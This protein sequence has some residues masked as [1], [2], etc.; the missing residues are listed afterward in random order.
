MSMT[1]DQLT[2]SVESLRDWADTLGADGADVD[3]LIDDAALEV[4]VT[5]RISHDAG[6]APESLTIV[7]GTGGPH[8]ELVVNL[9]SWAPVTTEA[10]GH[11]G[12]DH[13]VR[14]GFASPELA[15]WVETYVETLESVV[16]S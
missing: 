13:V 8:V 10:H 7:T 14:H 6:I 15:S 9:N 3:E 4:Y 16:S 1:L 11:W 2:S 12:S 5:A